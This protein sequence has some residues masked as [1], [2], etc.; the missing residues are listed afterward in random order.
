M[1]VSIRNGI[2]KRM[3]YLKPLAALAIAIFAAWHLFSQRDIDHPPGTLAPNEPLQSVVE[4]APQISVGEFTLTPRAS[5]DIEARVLSVERYN[6][7]PGA[8]LS[9]ID[10]A[11]G[12]GAM[13]SSELLDKF[14][15]SQGARFYSIYTEDS[16]VDIPAALRVSANMHLIPA[17]EDVR[18]MLFSTKPGH[19]VHLRGQLVTASKAD[20]FTWNTSLTRNDT[21]N[22]ACELMYVESVTRR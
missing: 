2:H 18:E 4:N 16:T 22:G 19:V 20:G 17:T 6:H 3:N 14:R 7:D 21:G 13:S 10:F 9:P 8:D 12:W 15:V 5:Y 11:M 1:P